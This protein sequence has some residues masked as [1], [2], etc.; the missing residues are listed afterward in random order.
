MDERQIIESAYADTVH[1]LY[2]VLLES[3]TAANGDT[4][5][6]AKAEEAFQKGILRA[7]HVRDR[8]LVLLPK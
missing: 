6:E 3:Y 4:K 5:A 2:S 1:I 8:A 7:R